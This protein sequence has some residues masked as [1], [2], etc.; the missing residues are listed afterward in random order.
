VLG[1]CRVL[2]QYLILD[3]EFPTDDLHWY[4]PFYRSQNWCLSWGCQWRD[5]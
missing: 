5:L 2:N 1:E 3:V 4:V